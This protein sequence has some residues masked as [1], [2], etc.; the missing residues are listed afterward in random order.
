MDS[1]IVDINDKLR[2]MLDDIEEQKQDY[3]GKLNQITDEIEQKLEEVKNYKE[4]F[5]NRKQTIEKMQKDISGFENDY[6]K[7]VDNLKDSELANILVSVNKEVSSKIDERKRMI[8][9]DIDAMNEL[10]DKAEGVKDALVQLKAEK[11]A[12]ELCYAK[13]S[14]IKEVYSKGFEDLIEYSKKADENITIEEEEPTVE[15]E[16]VEEPEAD[17][18]VT[19]I[20][21]EEPVQEETQDEL[22]GKTMQFDTLDINDDIASSYEPDIDIEPFTPDYNY[23]TEEMDIINL[24][25][26]NAKLSNIETPSTEETEIITPEEETNIDLP[27]SEE[28]NTED[29]SIGDIILPSYEDEDDDLTSGFSLD[30][31]QLASNEYDQPKEEPT[32]ENIQVNNNV[33]DEADDS[34]FSLDESSVIGEVSEIPLEDDDDATTQLENLINFGE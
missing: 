20:E 16:T 23:D 24:D 9:K 8:N 12:L 11:K 13:L 32:I 25:E 19:Q 5:Y 21:E 10:V 30:E 15:V 7:M 17:I 22:Y 14:N 34:G 6:Q 3:Q 29:G 18:Q 2:G 27:V 4:D 26:L 33:D 28:T 31:I 1:F